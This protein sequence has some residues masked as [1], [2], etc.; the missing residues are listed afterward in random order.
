MLKQNSAWNADPEDLYTGPYLI[1]P[2]IFA[3]EELNLDKFAPY[4][5]PVW[6]PLLNVSTDQTAPKDPVAAIILSTPQMGDTSQIFT[7][8]DL[9]K[10]QLTEAQ[11]WEAA[12]RT[13]DSMILKTLK[14]GI[15]SR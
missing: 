1:T 14:A 11:A 2:F 9:R 5:K 3:L 10:L 6:R 8:I 13:A 7:T 15:P 4:V 12:L